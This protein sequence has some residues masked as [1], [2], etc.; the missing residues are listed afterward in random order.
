MASITFPTES[1][2]TL[3]SGEE[4]TTVI[5]DKSDY[6]LMF[7]LDRG[8]GSLLIQNSAT[9]VDGTDVFNRPLLLKQLDSSNEPNIKATA[10]LAEAVITLSVVKAPASE[11]GTVS[12]P[13]TLD[14][15]KW[16]VVTGLT[17]G[18]LYELAVSSDAPVT[19]F[20]KTGTALTTAVENPPLMTQAGSIQFQTTGTSAWLY[21][22]G[23][24]PANVSLKP[25]TGVVGSVPPQVTQLNST[26]LTVALQGPAPAGY[27][28]LDVVTEAGSNANPDGTLTT[29]VT[30]TYQ[31]W[32]GLKSGA[33]LE[34]LTPANSKVT[35]SDIQGR[36]MFSSGTVLGSGQSTTLVTL[37]VPTGGTPQEF[38]GT[39]VVTF[40][41]NI[42]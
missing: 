14:P 30:P 6:I 23:A 29:N 7:T 11:Y 31:A 39:A 42:S 32:T 27:Y 3:N 35:A 4:Y 36:M 17:N 10:T 28:F 24:F 9:L 20:S 18:A 5:A 34:P 2:V 8:T 1:P 12:C 41:G 40:A 21:V 16:Y 13:A 19:V 37:T 38:S 26:I 22:D 25:F 15:D 33:M